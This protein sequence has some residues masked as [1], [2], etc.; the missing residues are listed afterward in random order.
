MG[1]SSGSSLC[2]ERLRDGWLS[3]GGTSSLRPAVL[4]RVVCGPLAVPVGALASA[5][6]LSARLSTRDR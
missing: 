2:P 5:H 1:Q 3:A 6:G 4:R